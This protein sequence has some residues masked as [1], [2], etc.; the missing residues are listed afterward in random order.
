MTD[1]ITQVIDPT[2]ASIEECR[3]WLAAQPCLRCKDTSGY[4]PVPRPGD[5]DF[6]A[7]LG[8]KGTGL[9]FPWASEECRGYWPGEGSVTQPCW[10][11]C[12]ECKGSGRV[13]KAVGLEELLEFSPSLV[14]PAIYDEWRFKSRP[15]YLLAALR[16]VVRSL[17]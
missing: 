7:C 2:T 3:R 16:A 8:C 10:S 13:P 12:E 4:E 14:A 1:S 15:H 17:L 5:I 9:A 11:G 6:G